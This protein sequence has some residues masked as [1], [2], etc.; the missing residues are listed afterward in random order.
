MLSASRIKD[1]HPS[2]ASHP[3]IAFGF[4]RIDNIVRYPAYLKV[5]RSDETNE[6]GVEGGDKARVKVFVCHS[7]HSPVNQINR[8]DFGF[9]NSCKWKCRILILLAMYAQSWNPFQTPYH[10]MRC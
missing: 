7:F 5:F 10:V 4:Q 1:G 2:Y 3:T 9:R 6:L 8:I